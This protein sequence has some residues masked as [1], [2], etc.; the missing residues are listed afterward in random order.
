MTAQPTVQVLGAKELRK[1]M[2]Q[3][4]DDLGDL[5]AVH[6]AAGN[7]V[8][9]AAQAL[10]P[11]RSGALAGSIRAA[12][13]AGGISVKV[14][15]AGIPYANPIHWG[16]P[17]RNIEAQPFLSDAATQTEAQWVALYEE[18]LEKIIQRVEGDE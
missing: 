8:V 12:K 2:K 7:I 17:K 14:G 5:K 4:G 6:Q 9:A 18:E 1:T 10:A 3:A 16:W 13:L 11:K 15:G